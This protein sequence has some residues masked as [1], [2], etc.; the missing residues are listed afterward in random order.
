MNGNMNEIDTFIAEL[1]IICDKAHP[2]PW[3]ASGNVPFNVDLCKPRPS[4]SK[5]DANRPTY[6]HVDDAMFVLNAR[7][8]LPRL[9]DALE[10]ARAQRNQQARSVT[11]L[12]TEDLA[13]LDIPESL[14]TLIAELR[15]RESDQKL[16]SEMNGGYYP[17]N[18]AML[19]AL[20][21]LEVARAQRK[22]L[23]EAKYAPNQPR[24]QAARELAALD[25]EIAKIL[26]GDK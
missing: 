9:L 4:L 8:M 7:V 15:K 5:H 13:N 20:D 23:I 26:R 18:Y 10:L 1:R 2:G 14:D 21:A 11:Y 3:T 17:P 22:Q 25:I 19:R 6:W 16:F 12:F 24:Q